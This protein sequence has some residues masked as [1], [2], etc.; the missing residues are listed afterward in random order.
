[1]LSSLCSN[2]EMPLE[3]GTY[4]IVNRPGRNDHGD[5]HSNNIN[6]DNADNDDNN[7]AHGDETDATRH[8]DEALDQ[9][10]AP[11]ANDVAAPKPLPERNTLEFLIIGIG[12]TALAFNAGFINGCTIQFRNIAVSHVTGTSTH[13]GLFLATH[14]WEGFSLDL[15]LIVCFIFGSGISGAF[16]PQRSFHLGA[17]YG[18]IFLIG[19][20]LLVL[21]CLI[22][23]Y[24]PASYWYFYF[25]AM[26]SGLQNALTTNY[27]G[28]VIRTTHM[29]GTSTDIGLVLGKLAMGNTKDIWKLKIL[30]PL[31]VAFIAGGAVSVNAYKQMGNLALAINV[32]VFFGVGL[33][34]SALVVTKYHV[35]LWRAFFGAY[36]TVG[37][38]VKQSS[39]R[40]KK[41]VQKGAKELKRVADEASHFVSSP[42][43]HHTV[44]NPMQDRSEG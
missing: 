8:N 6:G 17:Q 41:A 15:C 13:I 36:E 42:V 38:K 21:A 19:S 4:A 24:F 31:L 5:H 20:F 9:P 1:V 11:E 29:T 34:Y 40:A 16:V 44:I 26:A 18:P 35:P 43:R 12:G 30:V 39:R 14:N 33:S 2:Q 10:A 25:A 37:K 7:D 27:S 32:V 23:H 3:S 22:A 28:S